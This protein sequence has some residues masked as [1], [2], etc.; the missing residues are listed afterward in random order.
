[1]DNITKTI[2]VTGAAGFVGTSMCQRQLE[3]GHTVHGID[4]YITGTQRNINYLSRYP[5]FH[6]SCI[7]IT[8]AGALLRNQW[9]HYDEIYH[10]ACPTGVP[11][12]KKYGEEM[13]RTCSVGTENIL[14]LAKQHNARVLYTSSAEVYG[15][16]KEFPQREGYHGNVDP[17]GERAAY[18]E[19]KRFG[20]MLVQLYASKHNVQA[21]IV[22]IFNSFGPFMSPWDTRLIPNTLAKAKAGKPLVVY[23]DGTQTRTHLF[24]DDLLNGLEAVMAKGS[25]AYPYNVGGNRQR[26]I[27]ELIDALRK[28]TGLNLEVRYEPHYI[29]DHGGREPDISRAATLGWK[30]QVD[31]ATGLATMCQAYGVKTRGSLRK[32]ATTV[33]W[34]SPA[35]QEASA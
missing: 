24:I 20:E 7:D 32:N 19:G 26:S 25:L 29:E 8:D 34:P 15:D 13:M 2:L 14:L 18:E 35:L 33:A 10:F 6:F 4:N 27:N 28:V 21:T 1:M 16:P 30:P 31:L 9:S 22:R 17:V 12:I 3:N 23:G 5:G 11:N